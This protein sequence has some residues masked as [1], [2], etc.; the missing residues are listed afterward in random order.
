MSAFLFAA[1]MFA[2]TPPLIEAPVLP[3][4][5]EYEQMGIIPAAERLDEDPVRPQDDVLGDVW[6]MEEVSCWRGT[7]LRRGKSNTFDAYWKNP[8]GERER[9][10]LR[11]WVKGRNV[12]VYRPHEA[13][14]YCRY[15]GAIG[16]DWLSVEGRYSCT[17][18]R[19]PM[20]WQARILHM[21]PD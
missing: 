7:W 18:H 4:P 16:P 12:I 8:T 14:K 3:C 10:V 5:G 6:E 15:D 11:I 2:A 20:H 21:E 1:A 9:A 17:W 13:G 19:T